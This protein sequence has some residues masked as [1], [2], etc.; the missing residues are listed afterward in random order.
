M[1]SLKLML[2][3]T[4]SLYGEKTAIVY[5]DQKLAYAELDEASNKV[6]N[7]L[8]KLGVE[9]GDRVALLLSSS[10][11]Y[12][13]TF[14][15]IVKLGAIAVTLDINYKTNELSYLFNDALPKVLVSENP[16]LESLIPFLQGFRSI[17]H[18]IDL[19]SEYKGKFTSYQ[20]IMATSPGT[21]VEVE[22]KTE[23]TALIVYTSG[24]TFNPRGVVL[25]H[26]SLV[27]E[28]IMSAEGFQQTD[29]DIMMLYALPMHHVFGLVAA[30]LASI[31]KGSTVV[32]VPGTGLSITSFIAAIDRER[33]TMF[34]GVPYIFALAVDVAENE[35]IKNDLSSLR[36]C[37]SSGAPL[38]TDIMRR[39]K[40][41]YGYDIIDCWGMTEAVCHVTCQPANG[42]GKPGS[43][44]RPLS[45]WEVRVVD[46]NGNELPPNHTGELVIRGPI[47][48]EYYHNSRATSE[49]IK[50]GWLYSGDIGVT[51]ED[52]FV[53]VTGRKKDMIIVKGQNIYTSDIE[54]VLQTHP[55]VAEAAV[56]GIPDDMRGEIVGA[57]VSL[58]AGEKATEQELRGFC[59][60]NLI[61]YK[62]PKKIVLIDSL[63]KNADGKIDKEGIRS[64]LSIP[65]IFQKK[66]L[67]PNNFS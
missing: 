44:G 13:A 58:K 40:Q 36:L 2:E 15:G 42:T 22:P 29:N 28:A 18:I 32:M 54:I 60:E 1:I 37:S 26:N 64:R 34:L 52:G 5:G 57:V 45:K 35:G 47:M 27:L 59:V 10:P 56:L 31:Y 55:K 4:V 66:F 25:S 20:E 21:R 7:A 46:N 67:Q 65:S 16:T 53:Y 51:D 3:Q 6:A 50:D 14:F 8:I 17:K 41:Q 9:K 39:F 63:P 19:S 62:V 48:K 24:P 61:N 12:I 11:E 43:V 38:S 33:G 23:D 30:V 49:A